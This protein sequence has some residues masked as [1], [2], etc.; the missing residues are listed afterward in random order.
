M[1]GLQQ[2]SLAFAKVIQPLRIEFPVVDGSYVQKVAPIQRCG[3]EVRD[4]R[5]HGG[6]GRIV[7]GLG[8]ALVMERNQALPLGDAPRP[9]PAVPSICDWQQK[10]AKPGVP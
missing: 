10:H 8:R 3:V 2:L 5:L 6:N 7:S 1:P 9:A 4:N